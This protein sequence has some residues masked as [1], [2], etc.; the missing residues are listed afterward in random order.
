MNYIENNYDDERADRIFIAWISIFAAFVMLL[1]FA[2]LI[3][4][5]LGF[6]FEEVI[7]LITMK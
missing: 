7:N 5:S 2:S 3:M 4:Y 1:S 6:T